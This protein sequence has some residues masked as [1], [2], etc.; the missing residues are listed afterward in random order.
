MCRM[1]HDVLTSVYL[2]LPA[3]WRWWR[4]RPHPRPSNASCSSGR[5]ALKPSRR[6]IENKHS[7][8]MVA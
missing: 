7:T 2:S 8:E 1:W 6:V 5:R 3:G 4:R